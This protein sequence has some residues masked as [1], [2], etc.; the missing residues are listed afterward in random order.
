MACARWVHHA[1]FGAVIEGMDGIDSI[2]A[3]PTGTVPPH[4]NVP[5]IPVVIRQIRRLRS[6]RHTI[7]LGRQTS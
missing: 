1:L 7:H 6:S 2:A 5:L 3:S 4:Q